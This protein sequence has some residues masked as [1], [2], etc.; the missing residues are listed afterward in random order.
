VIF[1]NN[2]DDAAPQAATELA[3]FLRLIPECKNQ[4]KVILP[5]WDRRNKGFGTSGKNAAPTG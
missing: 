4:A 5:G 1:P 2:I 3:H